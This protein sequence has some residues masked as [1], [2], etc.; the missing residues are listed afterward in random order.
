M[1]SKIAFAAIAAAFVFAAN[2]E[3]SIEKQKEL[4][5]MQERPRIVARKKIAVN[6]KAYIVEEWRNAPDG[7]QV[8][9][10]E[11]FSVVGVKQPTSWSKVKAE[12]EAQLQAAEGDAKAMKD[13]KK[14]VKK[15]EKNISK[16]VK[17]IEKA[18]DKASSDEETE[19]YD[20]LLAILVVEGE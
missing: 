18:K 10:N 16:V 6:G 1:F 11:V 5:A 7:R 13:L 9:T 14:I 17:T 4:S 8:R 3:V 20:A 2:G 19:L 12:L 15:A